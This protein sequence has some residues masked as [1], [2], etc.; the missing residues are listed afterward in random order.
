MYVNKIRLYVAGASAVIGLIS[1][2]LTYRILLAINRSAEL[3]PDNL[4][5][6]LKYNKAEFESKL[7][8]AV[9]ELMAKGHDRLTAAAE[10]FGMRVEDLHFLVKAGDE[11]AML[12]IGFTVEELR[13]MGFEAYD[14]RTAE[15][16]LTSEETEQ[17]EAEAAQEREIDEYFDSLS[18][19]EPYEPYRIDAAEAQL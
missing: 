5:H 3:K 8:A 9:T 13:C 1:F 17:A 7:E 16:T 4:R 19:L 15:N 6:G 14:P 12:D 18:T 10:V 2:E 11:A